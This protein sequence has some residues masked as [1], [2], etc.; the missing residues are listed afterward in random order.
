MTMKKTFFLTAMALT[1]AGATVGAHMAG[2][3]QQQMTPNPQQN[4]PCM[5]NTGMMGGYGMG[6]GMM[7]GYGMG[8]GMMGG[9]GMG[10]GMMGGC[11]MGPGIMGGYGMGP[12]MM[13]G[14]GYGHGPCTQGNC[15]GQGI[16]PGQPGYMPPEKYQKFLDETKDLRK[17]MHDLRFEYGE[18]TRNPKTTMEEKDKM[19][20]EMFE[21]HQKIRGKAVDPE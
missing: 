2:G 16:A 5:M 19:E 11:G 3:A 12:G 21:L 9:C 4:Y 1:L 18:M 8:P 15:Y 14:Y 20:K 6:S 17:K 10:P 13:G 7:D